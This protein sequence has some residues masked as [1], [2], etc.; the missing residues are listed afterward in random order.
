M[1]HDQNDHFCAQIGNLTKCTI[2]K[3]DYTVTLEKIGNLTK[4]TIDKHDYTV[5]LEKT[6]VG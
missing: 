6:F 1:I 4:C 2:D 5:T 3:H